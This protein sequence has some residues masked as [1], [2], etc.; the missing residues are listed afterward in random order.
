MK[1]YISDIFEKFDALIDCF[2]NSHQNVLACL[3]ADHGILWRHSLEGK[4]SVI[5]DLQVDDKRCVRHI[6]GSR[7]RDY[8]LVK[9]GFGGTF[10][11]LR[12]PYITRKLRNNEWGVHGGISAWESIVPLIIRTT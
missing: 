2:S 3:T 1:H 7:I 9:S 4:W 8:I 11:M 12:V 5:N 10:S 6:R